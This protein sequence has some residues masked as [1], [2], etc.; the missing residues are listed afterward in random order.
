[1]GSA[2]HVSPGYKLTFLTM[3]ELMFEIFVKVISSK[4]FS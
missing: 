2:K 1:M 4:E 3:G